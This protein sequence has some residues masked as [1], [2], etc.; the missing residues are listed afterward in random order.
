MNL[1]FV[2]SHFDQAAPETKHT[3]GENKAELCVLVDY[4]L[5][6]Y[7]IGMVTYFVE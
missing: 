4:W 6:L 2:F 1:Y 5:V 3:K 7:I